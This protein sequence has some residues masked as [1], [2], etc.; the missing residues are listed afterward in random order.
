MREL[1]LAENEGEKSA[2]FID[3]MCLMTLKAFWT[4][5]VRVKER[6]ERTDSILEDLG[7][8]WTASIMGIPQV[9]YGIICRSD[10]GTVRDV[11]SRT[12]LKRTS[13]VVDRRNTK[14]P[15]GWAPG[16]D[17]DNA[18]KIVRF[19]NFNRLPRADEGE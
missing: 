17:F 14:S 8:G 13:S 2:E 4:K 9:Q 15:T 18:W 7:A 12:F 16:I 6:F 11:R 5:N 10:H 3:R 1:N 19:D